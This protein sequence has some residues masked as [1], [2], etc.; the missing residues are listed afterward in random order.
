MCGGHYFSMKHARHLLL[1][2]AFILSPWHT[3]LAQDKLTDLYYSGNYQEVVK[4]SATLISSG[5]TAFN[6]FYL[7]AL[8]ESQLGQAMEAI[9]SLQKALI[10][11]P[12]DIRFKRMLAR[13]YF[14]A[15][16]YV[17][18]MISYTQLVQSD[19]S[20]VASWLK[21]A[22]MASFRQQY[23]DAE[24]ALNQVL[25]ID[26]MNLSSLMMMGDI[27]NRHNNTG[28][29]IYYRRAY[30]MY[31]ENQKAAYALGNW[32]ILANEA[33]QTIPICEHMLEIDTTSI[34]FSK[35]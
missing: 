11:H 35:W 20:D 15:G 7:K 26:S 29:V 28:A 30:R 25:A 9:A 1:A 6:T 16:N 13:Q 27:L 14:D 22:E 2:F 34:K 10:L 3:L 23:R 5:D 21:L 19:S 33:W 12:G 24:G 4:G 18:A 17:E 31:P 32:L 8:S